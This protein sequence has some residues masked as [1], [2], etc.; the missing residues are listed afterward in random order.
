MIDSVASTCPTETKEALLLVT[1]SSLL[2]S[3][4]EGTEEKRKNAR[5]PAMNIILVL[6]HSVIHD[7]SCRAV[8]RAVVDTLDIH[9]LFTS[10]SRL[11]PNFD[12]SFGGLLLNIVLPP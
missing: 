7:R 5:L 4:E 12:P 9:P 6:I 10:P 3:R 2:F 8:P 11:Y 1:H